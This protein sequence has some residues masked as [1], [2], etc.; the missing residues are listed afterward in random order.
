MEPTPG[1]DAWYRREHPRLATSL[2]VVSGD[3]DAATDAADEAFARAL[4]RWSSVSHMA[5]P[6][7]WTYR[8][9][10]NVLRRR[11]RRAQLERR[12]IRNV[13]GIPPLEL[14]DPE[15]WD[16]VARLP[17]R[18]RTA[19]VLRYVADLPEADI[20]KAMGVARGTVAAT[21]AAARRRLQAELEPAQ[22]VEVEVPLD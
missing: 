14:P 13:T 9:A 11:M 10:L 19:V 8:V 12:V 21:L 3:L 2:L 7:G 17:R 5:S 18:Q 16:A 4:D 6:T 1:F 20:A 22:V 15:L